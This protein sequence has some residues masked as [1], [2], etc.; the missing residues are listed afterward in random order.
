MEKYEVL[1]S[2]ILNIANGQVAKKKRSFL[3]PA[4][5]MLVGVVS[6][7]VNNQKISAINNDSLTMFLFTVGIFLFFS[8]FLM[9]FIRKD[10]YVYLPTGKEIK[11]YTLDFDVKE[12]DKIMRLYDNNEFKKMSNLK[13]AHNSGLQLSLMGTEDGAMFY[14]QMMKYVPYAFVPATKVELHEGEDS[15]EIMELITLCRK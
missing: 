14:S 11:R 6:M 3:L 12:L 5:L 1:E 8:G 15:K 7:L 10:R 2:D 9:L 4:V 13:V